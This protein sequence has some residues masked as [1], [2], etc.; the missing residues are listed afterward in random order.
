MIMYISNDG[1]DGGSKRGMTRLSGEFGRYVDIRCI[2]EKSKDPQ[3][4]KV[5]R[6]SPQSG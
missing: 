1:L 4:S 5:G 6:L 2:E 3:Q